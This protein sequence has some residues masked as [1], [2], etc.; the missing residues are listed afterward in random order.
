MSKTGE[1]D[2]G[3]EISNIGVGES[4]EEKSLPSEIGICNRKQVSGIIG[5]GTLDSD[6]L[7]LSDLGSGSA[8]STNIFIFIRNL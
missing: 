8:E 5:I 2:A 7:N 6:P 1:K 3:R 4:L